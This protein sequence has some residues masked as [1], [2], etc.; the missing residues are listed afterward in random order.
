MQDSK[1]PQKPIDRLIELVSPLVER[2]GYE[3][4][5]LEADTGRQKTLRIYIENREYDKAIGVEDCVAVTKAIDEPLD[6]MPEVDAIFHGTYE[7]EVSSP[8]VDRPLRKP[9]DY[10]RFSG[11]EARIH[12]FRPL[13][14]EEIG[15]P[16]YQQKNT[17]QKNF[18]GML[19]G[20]R[21]EK[22]VL[23]LPASKKAS[24]AEEVTIPLSLI[25]KANLEP[26]F[27][28]FSDKRSR[29]Q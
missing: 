23:E 3:V 4:A 1:A 11:K 9:A 6:L 27:E 16:A 22:V 25:S 29:K 7:L 15:N 21:N 13:T 18:I 2:L 12:V 10:E 24:Q 26:K 8:G 20:L 17:K 19:K 5:H 28:A 14:P